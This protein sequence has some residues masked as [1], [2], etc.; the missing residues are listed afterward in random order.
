MGKRVLRGISLEAGSET[1][2]RV[3][4]QVLTFLAAIP[5]APPQNDRHFFLRRS[6][7]LVEEKRFPS[8]TVI[9]VIN[10]EYET[11]FRKWLEFLL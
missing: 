6:L 2:K 5:I 7:P 9:I 10:V 4:L 8:I 1:V 3:D 11:S